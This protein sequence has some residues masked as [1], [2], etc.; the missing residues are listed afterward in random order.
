M[1]GEALLKAVRAGSTVQ[2]VGLL[3]G[4]TDGERRAALPALKDLRK[5]LR[6][7]PWN[8]ESRTAYPALHAAGAACHTGAAA[9]AAWIAGA[10]MRWSQASPVSSCMCWAT[11]SRTGSPT[12]PSGWPPGRW[13]PGSRSCCSQGW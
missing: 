10:D 2:A 6:A 9:A 13:R 3:D 8:A 5:E 4:M 12:S 11:G 1:S 7:A